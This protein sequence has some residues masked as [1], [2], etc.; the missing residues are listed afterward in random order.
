MINKII[1][2]IKKHEILSFIFITYLC[3]WSI[4]GI[5]YSSY[6]GII[7]KSLHDEHVTLFITLGL[8]MPSTM[9]II[10]TG[11]L[12]KRKGLKQLLIRLT[13]WKFNPIYYI[14]AICYMSAMFYVAFLICSFSG[15]NLKINFYKNPII[16]LFYAILQLVLGGPLGEEIGWRGFLL[17]RLQRK[18]SP[19]QASLVIGIVWACW[20]LP[21]F[22]I[23]S[24][25]QY[26]TSFKVF[27][28]ATIGY[29]IAIT[30][31]FNRTNGSL[32]FPLLFHTAI[33]TTLEMIYGVMKVISS[34]VY[35]IAIAELIFIGI[36]V[37]DMVKRKN[38]K[39][40]V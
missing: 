3:S 36:I 10:L 25:A 9:S 2:H 7:N 5:L 34:H 23:A 8:F 37:L 14:I 38:V 26:G 22:F 40:T 4:W 16:I 1:E 31:V 11:C 35:T 20:H 33:N 28:I 32:I 27:L 21:L 17:P 13:N 24:T 39:F 12:Y 29:A 18:L 15:D 6:I 19:F 30:W